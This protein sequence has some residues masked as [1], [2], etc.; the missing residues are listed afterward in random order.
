M[1]SDWPQGGSGFDDITIPPI[2]VDGGS[3]EAR[4]PTQNQNWRWTIKPFG[5]PAM[6]ELSEDVVRLAYRLLLDRIPESKT[7]IEEKLAHH[8]TIRDLREH[9]V[10]SEEFRSLMGVSAP[11]RVTDMSE[12]HRAYWDSRGSV[13]V[14][15]S[16]DVL[17]SMMER[18]REQ[19]RRLGE[20][21]PYWSVLTSPDFKLDVMD[22][23][24]VASF[25]ETGRA[26]AGLVDLLAE[27]SGIPIKQGKCLELG[28][29]VGRV[30]AHLARR[31]TRV[32]AV[33]ISPGNLALC[34]RRM[35]QLAL[36][37]VE[38]V[39]LKSPDQLAQLQPFDFFYSIIVLQHNPP[40]I[41]KTILEAILG[42][43][44]PG[45]L[46]LFQTPDTFHSRYSFSASE[47]LSS[48]QLTMDMHCL[49]KVVVLKLLRDH[50]MH[51]LD[52]QPDPWTGSFGSYTYF[53]AKPPATPPPAGSSSGMDVARRA[54]S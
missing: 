28:C 42:R 41:Q 15:V 17:E 29:G 46:C 2:L 23:E 33:D 14:E 10:S 26:S 6:S 27:R 21:E 5:V 3:I 20:A 12:T 51:V 24:R 32:V 4:R 54:L 30:T 8:T 7:V 43:L 18:V 48:E 50:G 16:P 39:L 1:S 49:P 9:F 22:A 38:T 45:G 31:F 44:S 25:Y 11:Q 13:E 52:V 34:E 47:Y 36:H 19:W 40:P 35:K 37:N 53:A